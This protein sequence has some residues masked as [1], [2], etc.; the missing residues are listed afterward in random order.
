MPVIL[1]NAF[2]MAILCAVFLSI[3]LLR[4]HKRLD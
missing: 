3:A 2:A 4:F 1:P